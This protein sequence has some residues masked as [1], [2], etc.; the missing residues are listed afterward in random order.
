MPTTR[1]QELEAS[2]NQELSDDLLAELDKRIH[3]QLE[4]EVTRHLAKELESVLEAKFASKIE[5]LTAEIAGLRQSNENLMKINAAVMA[6]NKELK[7]NLISSPDVPSPPSVTAPVSVPAPVSTSD[8]AWNFDRE[9]PASTREYFD[10]LVLSDSIFRHV[11]NI[12]PKIRRDPN[13]PKD[14][15]PPPIRDQFDIGYASIKKIVMPGARVDALL[16]EASTLQHNYEFG[17][18]IVHCGAN[19]VPSCQQPNRKFVMVHRDEV[20]R[21]IKRLLDELSDMFSCM[22]TFSFIL[23][24][25]D[26]TYINDIN[27]INNGVDRHCLRN[28]FGIF[29]CD[30]FERVNGRLNSALFAKDGIH[31]GPKGIA[32]MYEHL[33]EHVKVS[34]KYDHY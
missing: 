18:I 7:E 25:M 21:D 9:S 3:E 14:L 20:S 22:I 29:R 23:P 4:S 27:Y 12:C 8:S 15:P 31:L 32:A 11:G 26:T 28:G 6:E 16:A 2:R 19:Y 13:A 17:E 5:A 33:V 1:N 24:Q 10:V 34:F 30:E